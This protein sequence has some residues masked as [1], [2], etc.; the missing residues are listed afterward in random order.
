MCLRTVSG[1]TVSA[2]RA[3]WVYARWPHEQAGPK[4]SRLGRGRQ[5]RRQAVGDVRREGGG[6]AEL[7]EHQLRY[8]Q[9]HRRLSERSGTCYPTPARAAATW[10]EG[11][12]PPASAPEHS[13]AATSPSSAA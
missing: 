10:D 9:I 2:I 6:G 1:S 5:Q 7:L 11:S 8:L 12:T 13:N 3:A 4:Q